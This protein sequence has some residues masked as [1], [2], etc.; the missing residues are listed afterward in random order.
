MNSTK[1]SWLSEVSIQQLE[2]AVAFAIDKI[3]GVDAWTLEKL[4]EYVDIGEFGSIHK[5]E[6]LEKMRLIRSYLPSS[7]QYSL[8]MLAELLDLSVPETANDPKTPATAG[9]KEK[10][11]KPQPNYRRV[12]PSFSGS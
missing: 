3:P 11:I 10:L 2:T 5:E 9:Q 1:K 4:L 12:V 8:L 6:L 7:C